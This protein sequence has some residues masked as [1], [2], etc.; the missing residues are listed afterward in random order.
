MIKVLAFDLGGVLFSNGGKVLAERL[1]NQKKYD[2]KIIL[3]LIYTKESRLLRT[4][5]MSD[6][7][8]W[9]FAQKMLPNGYNAE[10]IKKFW[11]DCYE[12][13]K[14]IFALMQKLRKKF[15]I[16]AF[17]GNIRSRVLYLERKYHFRHIFHKEVYSFDHGVSKPKKA[18]IRALI[19]EAGVHPSEILYVDDRKREIIHAKVLGINVLL[20][21]SGK[22]GDLK[23]RFGKLGI[24]I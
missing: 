5:K 2:P 16:I 3:D 18:F 14:D 10:E 6:K 9:A 4:G 15:T 1:K 21:Q 20:Y 22:I 7:E 24:E 8:F 17:S 19:K 13:D 12:L 11:Y 23:K